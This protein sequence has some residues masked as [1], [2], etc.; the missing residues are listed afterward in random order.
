[1]GNMNLIFY[2]NSKLD[3]ETQKL[4]ASVCAKK[5]SC[6]KPKHLIFSVFQILY[7]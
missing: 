6:S 4:T 5:K 7:N 3:A 1:M 2:L